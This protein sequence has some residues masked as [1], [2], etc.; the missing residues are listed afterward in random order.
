MLEDIVTK[1]NAIPA[2]TPA[3]A[4]LAI[5]TTTAVPT[6]TK[7]TKDTDYPFD[8]EE[9]QRIARKGIEDLS[10]EEP[11]RDANGNVIVDEFAVIRR[12]FLSIMQRM[13]EIPP[14]PPGPLEL[15]PGENE[16][17]VRRKIT[18]L[19]MLKTETDDPVDGPR[20]EADT[21]ERRAEIRRI[22][23]GIGIDAITVMAMM[24]GIVFRALARTMLERFRAGKPIYGP[25]DADD[26]EGALIRT[27]LRVRR[28]FLGRPET[29]GPKR[30]K[31]PQRR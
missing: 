22:V 6:V 4:T 25:A 29:S 28:N 7:V 21:L 14:P 2:I 19:R 9:M 11:S 24:L 15:P 18:R 5:T 20:I 13:L 17:Y 1:T 30:R 31:W 26:K 8:Y 10:R 3:P 16:A 27:L 12:M 23:L